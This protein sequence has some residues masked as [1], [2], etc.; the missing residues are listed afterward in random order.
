MHYFEV[1]DSQ[2][3]IE[4]PKNRKKD[5]QIKNAEIEKG[6]GFLVTRIIDQ[7]AGMSIETV[8][9]AINWQKKK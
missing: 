1:H 9:Q 7:G 6:H 2:S 4:T 3:G 5:N 8:N